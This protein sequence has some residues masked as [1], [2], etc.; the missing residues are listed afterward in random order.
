MDVKKTVNDWFES[1]HDE[2]IIV[3]QRLDEET[4]TW[5]REEKKL[6]LKELDNGIY[7]IALNEED[8][9]ADEEVTKICET[10]KERTEK[11]QKNFLDR[12][13]I[14]RMLNRDLKW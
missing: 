6:F 1:G 12:L 2:P 3:M 14:A 7:M 9:P 8:L 11:A 5:V 4:M 10:C 13:R